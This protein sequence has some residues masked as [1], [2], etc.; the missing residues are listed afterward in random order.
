MLDDVQKTLDTALVDDPATGVYKVG[1][2]IFT[3]PAIFELE[4]KYIFEGNWIR[5]RPCGRS[6]S[7]PGPPAF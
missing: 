1:Q 7:L 6:L 5:A 4:M 2:D 3:E